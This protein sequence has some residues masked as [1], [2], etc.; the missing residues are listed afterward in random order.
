MRA[1]ASGASHVLPHLALSVGGAAVG[2][3]VAQVVGAIVATEV[4]LVLQGQDSVG[5]KL[6]RAPKHPARTDRSNP[7]LAYGW[8]LTICS[9]VQ[10]LPT[11]RPQAG[12]AASRLS[13][14]A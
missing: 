11:A 10:H 13:Q 1:I 8:F 3:G 5:T 14:H 4:R 2:V 12:A 7:L 9:R 6:S